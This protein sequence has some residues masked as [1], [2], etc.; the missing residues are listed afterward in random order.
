MS[1]ERELREKRDI[2]YKKLH[3]GTT[4]VTDKELTPVKTTRVVTCRNGDKIEKKEAKMESDMSS[5][6]DSDLDEQEYDSYEDIK[7]IKNELQEVKDQRRSYR[8]RKRRRNYRKSWKNRRKLK[9][10]KDKGEFVKVKKNVKNDVVKVKK[11]NK[12]VEELTLNK[13]RSDNVIKTKTRLRKY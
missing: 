1:T 2:D 11:N 3:N 5:D 4:F 13:L 9:K 12:D 6:S 8:K 7:R 10:E